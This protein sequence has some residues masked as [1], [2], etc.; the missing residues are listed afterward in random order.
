MLLITSWITESF[1][2]SAGNLTYLVDFFVT[3][4]WTTFPFQYFYSSHSHL[5]LFSLIELW[6]WTSPNT[7]LLTLQVTI[8]IIQILFKLNNHH[9]SLPPFLISKVHK[10]DNYFHPPPFL[11]FQIWSQKFINQILTDK[12]LLIMDVSIPVVI[13]SHQFHVLGRPMY[14]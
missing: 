10:L 1:F 14:S 9:H 11:L 6:P 12:Y 8:E 2:Q 4:K 3:I 13:V 5:F 7:F